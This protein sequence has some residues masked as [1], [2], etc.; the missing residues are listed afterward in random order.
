MKNSPPATPDKASLAIAVIAAMFPDR[1]IM[2]LVEVL[3]IVGL[4]LSMD[5]GSEP[6]AQLAPGSQL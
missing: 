4:V 3:T 5:R 2:G 6:V 1:L